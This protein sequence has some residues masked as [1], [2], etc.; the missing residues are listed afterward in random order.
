MSKPQMVISKKLTGFRQH[1]TGKF[2]VT[3]D[4]VNADCP[5][6]NKK[7]H[8]YINP[9]NLLWDCKRCGRSGNFEQFLHQVAI[10]NEKLITPPM[11]KKI[12]LN[13]G[14]RKQTLM[15]W[16]VGYN[17]HYEFY[18]IPANGNQKRIT[19]DLR[20]YK[21]GNSTYATS[22]AK[23]SFV[24]PKEVY[25]SETVW[26]CEGEWDGMAWYEVLRKI[27]LHDDVYSV[28]G[29]NNFPNNLMPLLDNKIVNLLYDN[30]DVGTVGMQKAFKRLEFIAKKVNCIHWPKGLPEGF[31][32]RDLYSS[33][34]KIARHTFS[35]VTR[36][37]EDEV[38]YTELEQ[39]AKKERKNAFINPGVSGGKKTKLK[40]GIGLKPE[41]VLERYSKWLAMQDKHVLDIIY[42]A[43]F[44]N[45]IPGDPLW[46]FLV[47]PPGGMKSELLMSLADAPRVYTTTT[48]TPR[49]LIS[50][51]STMG[52]GDPSLIP[53][54]NNKVLVIKDF[55]TILS[56]NALAK[57]EIFS[58]FR[59]I[60][61]GKISKEFGNGTLRKYESRFGILAGVTN[62]IEN[63]GKTNTAL[64]ERFLKYR[65]RAT[66]AG[67]EKRAIKKALQNIRESEKMRKELKE[68]ATKVLEY[69]P[70]LNAITEIDDK[71]VDRFTEL[72][73]WVSKLRGIVSREK[74][75]NMV[76]Y[77]PT[78]E[79]GTRLATQFSK[80][81]Y[82]I[83]MYR[84]DEYIT[85]EVY[86]LVATVARNTI[87]DKVEE[88]VKQLFIHNCGREYFG[89]KQIS[90]W[91]RFPQET[92]RYLLQDLNLLKIV[93]RDEAR[94]GHWK[95]RNDIIRVMEFLKLYT[96]EKGWMDR[97]K[98]IIEEKEIKRN[99]NGGGKP[100]P[101]RK[102]K[103][104]PKRKLK[105]RLK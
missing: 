26:V 23:L 76:N 7:E 78:R 31:D 58:V 72:A 65:I 98:E 67:A 41:Q 51:A 94:V 55:T 74:Y 52:G 17:P 85:D 30:D 22:G 102:P 75:T 47:A 12:C 13:R 64:G 56:M 4:Q 24:V 101:K 54:L 38:P 2:D 86:Q 42:G 62:E 15:D 80:L 79:V 66:Q 81:A 88:V 1:L 39:S 77:K 104:K 83:A 21:I 73:R 100:K 46:L 16:G 57:D 95:L 70:D 93:D 92:T 33:K 34:N 8:L 20:K 36:W 87:P 89:V 6:C 91:S 25:N 82:G 48:L 32:I 68:I 28:I 59:D 44:A 19:T 63:L 3:D 96:L 69:Q 27:E 43:V 37:L 10:E 61:D 50:G 90:E 71:T 103:P 18:T 84:R 45:R 105:K 97:N 5:F 49:A 29:A 9:N 35:T 99:S 53:K 14:L 40:K 60:Y 11:L